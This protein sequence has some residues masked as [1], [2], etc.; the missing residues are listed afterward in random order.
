[1]SLRFFR[2]DTC[3]RIDLWEQDSL[4]TGICCGR[5]MK[6]LPVNDNEE[7][8]ER[9]EPILN[10]GKNHVYVTIGYPD[11]VMNEEHHI[12]WLALETTEDVRIV[13]PRLGKPVSVDCYPKEPVIAVYAYC[14][15]HGLWKTQ[16]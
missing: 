8:F 15:Q 12:D 16:S 7:F 11:H 3:G 9:H 2:C 13:Y 4:E 10:R 6:E 5:K 1:M 14:N